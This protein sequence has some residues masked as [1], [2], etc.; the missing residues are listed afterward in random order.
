MTEF[1]NV[2]NE[3]VETDYKRSFLHNGN[4]IINC[5]LSTCGRFSYSKEE[6]M[7]EYNLTELQYDFYNSQKENI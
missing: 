7:K 5:T 4:H 6:S 1:D 3:E 2:L